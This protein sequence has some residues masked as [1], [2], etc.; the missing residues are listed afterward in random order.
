MSIAEII[1]IGTELLLGEI[2]D[3]N[4]RFLARGLREI[5]I[6]L[7]RTSIVGDNPNRI[8][9]ILKESLLRTD[10]LIT[11]GGLGPTVDDPT[12]DAVSLALGLEL[13]FHSELWNQ[14][15][16]RFLSRG[17][18][19]TDNNRKQ[20]YIPAGA[21]VIQNPVGTAP[22]FYIKK[23]GKLIICLPGVPHEME[24]LF[25]NDVISILKQNYVDERIIQLRTLHVSGIGESK[26][27]ELICDFERLSNPT[28]G[29]LSHPGIVD[30]RIT[31]QSTS[32]SEAAR[33]L[34]EI[35]ITLRKLFPDSIFGVDGE[36]LEEA[37][38][39]QLS[40]LN[41]RLHISCAGFSESFLKT[42]N[43]SGGIS[44][45]RF[46]AT[47][48]FSD[49]EIEQQNSNPVEKIS[50]YCSF[51]QIPNESTHQL[52]LFSTL[53]QNRVTCTFAGP[54]GLEIEWAQNNCL[55]F[56]WRE[57]KSYIRTKETYGQS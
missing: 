18:S 23:N 4:T 12:R 45:L 30:I 41:L 32:E 11:T 36:T 16:N 38:Q 17:I 48:L 25:V 14:I 8:S 3:T 20:A 46:P 52:V 5:G 28:V 21:T 9:E 56:I 43:K 57:L 1:S 47:H 10:V 40:G 49:A 55:N 24:F 33:S 50:V 31:T 2:L 37:I 13:E 19:P 27:D 39:A 44:I 42:L 26:V 35:E 29:L 53:R 34:D 54:P 22:A 51:I 15:Q 7:Y 6:N